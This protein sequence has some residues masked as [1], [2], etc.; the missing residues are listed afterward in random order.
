M[1]SGHK[2]C[3]IILIKK[4]KDKWEDCLTSPGADLVGVYQ[5]PDCSTTVMQFQ[6]EDLH[7]H[8]NLYF[9]DGVQ[10]A[11]RTRRY[12]RDNYHQFTVSLIT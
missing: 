5:E 9:K 3:G 2:L 6:S 11:S 10:G 12:D 4:F 7:G 8:D 1:F